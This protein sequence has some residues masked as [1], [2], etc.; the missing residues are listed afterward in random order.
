MDIHKPK[1]WHGVREF[2]K[3]YVIIVVGV[4]TALAAEAMVENLHERRLSAEARD[5]VR[6]E[7]NLDLA[8]LH[9]RDEWE[10]C[11]Q[12]RFAQLESALAAA[13]AGRPFPTLTYIGRPNGIQFYT[14]RWEAA[15]S[16]GRTTLLSSEEQLDFARVYAALKIFGDRQQEETATWGRLRAIEGVSHPSAETLARAREAFSEARQADYNIRRV[17][18]GARGYAGRIGIKGDAKLVEINHR[19]AAICLPTTTRRADVM[20][21]TNDAVGDP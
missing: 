21:L 12:A 6:S 7:I 20:A 9:Q 11:V 19:M 17:L 1:P 16:G 5:A 3:E 4:L 10:P 18:L 15:T 2:L 13:D 14:Q 8:S